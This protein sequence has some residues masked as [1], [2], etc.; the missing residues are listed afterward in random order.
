MSADQSEHSTAASPDTVGSS[1]PGRSTGS[2]PA[3]DVPPFVPA[4]GIRG[5]HRQ[6]IVGT[7]LTGRVHLPD[8]VQRKVRVSDDDYIVLHDDQPDAWKRGQPV[9]LMLHGLSGGYD[10]GYMQ[11]IAARLHN[12]GVRAFRMDHRGCGA[13]H[14]LAEKPYHAG[15]I[16][17][18][19][20]AIAAVEALCPD[21][22]ISV[23]GFSLSGNLVLRYLGD[24]SFDHSA[25]L[26]RAVAVCPPVDL[27][28][29]VSKL[30]TTRAGQRYDRYFT[31]RLIDQIASSP[32]WRDDVPLAQAKRPPRRLYDFDDMYTAPASGFG[33]ADDYYHFASASPYIGD[34][35][36]PTTIL[37]ANDDPLVCPRPLTD[38][39]LPSS[40]SLCLTDH[41]GHL[42]YVARR[43]D[44]QDR[45]WMDWRVIEWLL[46]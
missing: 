17:D 28:H 31:R 35:E 15:R 13:G 38:L 46:N 42:G 26:H 2:G 19:H 8:T 43:N 34:I 1:V 9:V 45:R 18:L 21:S 3:A 4:V 37:A 27:R 41:G 24:R 25:R 44:D 33:R 36:L 5:G 23:V 14:G 39:S 32:Q 6:T 10:S 11:R 29:C 20:R 16:D 7:L 30:D 12:Q 22:P 40:V